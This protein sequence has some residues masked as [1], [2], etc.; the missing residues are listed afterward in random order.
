M[1]GQFWKGNEMRL[2]YGMT[3]MAM[4]VSGTSTMAGAVDLC[5]TL[6]HVVDIRDASTRFAST[7]TSAGRQDALA[8][9]RAGFAALERSDLRASPFDVMRA[10]I[11]ALLLSRLDILDRVDRGDGDMALAVARGGPYAERARAFDASYRSLRC[12]A[13]RTTSHHSVSEDGETREP[14]FG[15]TPALRIVSAPLLAALAASF[16]AL[17]FLGWR[18]LRMVLVRRKRRAKR[19][20]CLLDIGMRIDGAR[21]SARLH[22]LSQVGCK[23]AV[24]APLR[25]GDTVTL[26]MPSAERRGRVIWANRHYAG[27]EFDRHLSAEQVGTI[28]T[29]EQDRRQPQILGHILKGY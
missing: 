14:E 18:Y 5:S 25:K 22:D 7:G 3:V 8:E 23:L 27:I 17:S 12:T 28:V 6:S 2:R 10:E 21:H 16:L 20:S 24:T 4:M 19:F 15:P 9:M 1:E 29:T 26:A 13:P 11:D